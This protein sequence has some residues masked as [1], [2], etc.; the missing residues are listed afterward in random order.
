MQISYSIAGEYNYIRD[1]VLSGR[2]SVCKE[3]KLR[4]ELPT[5]MY[6][7]RDIDIPYP[8]P[9]KEKSELGRHLST[10]GLKLVVVSRALWLAGNR[11]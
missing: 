5:A 6:D 3:L 2:V 10:T 7:A 9:K 4:V 1:I 11:F 8:L